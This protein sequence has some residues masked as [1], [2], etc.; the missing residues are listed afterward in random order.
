V[1]CSRALA[2]QGQVDAVHKG[3]LEV[4]MTKLAYLGTGLLIV[5]VLIAGIIAG[6]IQIVSALAGIG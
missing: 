6:C 4:T 3:A 2:L 1:A 5:L